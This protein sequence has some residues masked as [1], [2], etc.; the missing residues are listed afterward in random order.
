MILEMIEKKLV[1]KSTSVTA[2]HNTPKHTIQPRGGFR[3]E[4]LNSKCLCGSN[5]HMP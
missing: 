2:V 1:C 4:S 3:A 5:Q